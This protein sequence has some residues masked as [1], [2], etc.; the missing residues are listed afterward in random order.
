MGELHLEIYIERM[1]REYEV[2]LAVGQPKVNY[3]E[4]VR[5]KVAFNYL[6]KK[7][8]GGSGQFGRVM[9][10]IEP[11][12]P[13]ED[14]DGEDGGFGANSDE[15]DGEEEEDA[16]A[17]GLESF[18]FVN[19][20]IGM[21]IPSE[22]IPSCEKGAR[23]ACRKGNLIGAPIQ[24]LRVVLED[25]QSHAVDSSDLA[26]ALAMQGAVRE[27]VNKAKPVVLEPVMLT[28]IVAPI[29]FQGQVVAGISKRMGVV[30]SS[31]T[32][33]DGSSVELTADVPLA[34]MFG[35]STELRS[36]TQGKGEF[37]MAY[38]EHS[39]VPS[40]V[41]ETLMKEHQARLAQKAA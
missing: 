32:S 3:R 19:N 24:G 18:E 31:E 22:Y 11:L 14:D 29:E 8:S 33:E 36:S 5:Q 34:N 23:M 20:V 40:D 9:G 15:D 25:G 38:K 10:W 12:T 16:A 6:H 2:D 13:D 21:N 26:F 41:Q 37:T 27:A 30:Q 4:T 39:P 7:Q 28:E 35:Y 1:L 17:G